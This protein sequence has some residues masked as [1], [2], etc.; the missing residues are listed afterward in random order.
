MSE[1]TMYRVCV[2]GFAAVAAC[3]YAVENG[4]SESVSAKQTDSYTVA[5]LTFGTE[6][7]DY[8]GWGYSEYDVSAKDLSSSRYVTKSG[9]KSNQK[10]DYAVSNCHQKP[11]DWFVWSDDCALQIGKTSVGTEAGSLTIT[12]KGCRYQSVSV[13]AD[14]YYSSGV[15]HSS[16]VPF[17]INGESLTNDG[18]WGSSGT[19]QRDCPRY[20]RYY[21]GVPQS[22]L[23]ISVPETAERY[24]TIYVQ[25]I[26][27]HLTK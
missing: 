24:N 23:I 22:A 25:K 6:V 10:L 11:S 8:A 7:R 27:F 2:F 18:S 20:D 3:V 5:T 21:C 12:L 16:G 26:V 4:L 14:T 1:K 19:V 9:F 13:Y 15:Y 17:A